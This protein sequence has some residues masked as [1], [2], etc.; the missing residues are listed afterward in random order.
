[1]PGRINRGN[2]RARFRPVIMINTAFMYVSRTAGTQ[3]PAGLII[4]QSLASTDRARTDDLC[5]AAPLGR[6]GR[7]PHGIGREDVFNVAR[8]ALDLAMT[9]RYE[10]HGRRQDARSAVRAAPRTVSDLTLPPPG[11]AEP[12]RTDLRQLSV[13]A[14]LYAGPI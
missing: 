7:Q 13:P 11:F 6:T 9:A 2:T 14:W 1:M 8:Y 10:W 12:G 5:P 3:R 4:R